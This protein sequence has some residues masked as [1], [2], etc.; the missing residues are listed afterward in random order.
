MIY[1]TSIMESVLYHTSW[2]LGEYFRITLE[3]Y[4]YAKER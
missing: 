1:F 4:V 3:W 2:R